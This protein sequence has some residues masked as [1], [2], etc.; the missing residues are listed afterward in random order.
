MPTKTKRKRN[1]KGG[2]EPRREHDSY[3]TDL[4]LARAICVAVRDQFG[5]FDRVVEPSAGSGRFVQAARETWLRA[6]LVAVEPFDVASVPFVHGEKIT[7]LH[8]A[9]ADTVVRATWE[10]YG[11]SARAEAD[12]VRELVIGNP[13]FTLAE[14]HVRIALERAAA[15]DVVVMLLRSSILGG[16]D[17]GR[18]FWKAWPPVL[19]WN[20]LPRPSF[21]GGGTDGAEYVA[22]A[23][24][25]PVPARRYAG[26]WLVWRDSK[27]KRKR[28]TVKAAP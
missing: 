10:E 18:G 7:R 16:D 13:P 22:I 6:Q 17:R 15:G 19:V 9:G 12:D 21:T 26:D 11:G 8:D 14:E 1:T 4:E 2:E 25:L 28:R 27:R 5:S 3:I 23:W 20:L 24:S